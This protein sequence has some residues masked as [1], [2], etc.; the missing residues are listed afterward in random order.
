VEIR[1][2]KELESDAAVLRRSGQDTKWQKLAETLQDNTHML[3]AQR[4][5]RKLVIFTE[6]RDTLNYLNERLVTLLGNPAAVVTIHGQ[7]PREKRRQVQEAF[8]SDPR[9]SSSSPPMQPVKV[10]TFNART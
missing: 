3:D 10:S 9:W 1:L 6:Q 5:L 7:T 2:L 4:Q 8:A